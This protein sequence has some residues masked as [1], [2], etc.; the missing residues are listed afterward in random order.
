MPQKGRTA[1]LIEEGIDYALVG[2]KDN[3][4]HEIGTTRFPFNT[5]CHIERDFG[6]GKWR[7]CTGTLIAPRVVLVAGHCVYN[8]RLRRAP[9]RIRVSPG[10]S[11]LYNKPYGSVISTRYYVPARFIRSQAPAHPDRKDFDYGMI[12]LPR[13]FRGISRF[14]KIKA[15]SGPEFEL[16][17]SRGD[18]TIAGYPADRP[19][20]SLWRHTKK[21]KGITPRRLF[22]TVDTCPGHSGS[23]IWL[24][25]GRKPVIIG[26]HT[27][28]AVD[29]FGRA[30]GCSRET[31]IAPPGMVNSGVRITPDL[32]AGIT[33]PDRA[34]AWKGRMVRLPL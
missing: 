32:L 18:V 29:E 33:N 12:V 10:R 27:S 13:P 24:R 31:V 5:I 14:M 30:Y 28:G 20:G 6:D 25:E 34:I 15:L 3:R 4:V 2:R 1:Q 8:H 7:G 19:I 17:K 21:L 22:Y 9:D 16:L 23:S 11:D 26:I